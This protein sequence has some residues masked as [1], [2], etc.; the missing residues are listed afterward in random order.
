[1]DA[2]LHIMNIPLPSTALMGLFLFAVIA[3]FWRPR[4]RPRR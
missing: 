1:M 3:F 4:Y 2:W